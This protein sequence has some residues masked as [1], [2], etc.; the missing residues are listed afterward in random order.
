MSHNVIIPDGPIPSPSETNSFHTADS[1]ESIPDDNISYDSSREDD[2]M[3]PKIDELKHQTFGYSRSDHHNVLPSQRGNMHGLPP[4]YESQ[5]K[6]ALN[7]ESEVIHR[8]L[9]P[10]LPDDS[11]K[12]CTTTTGIITSCILISVSERISRL[13][14]NDNYRRRPSI[15]IPN[16]STPLITDNSYMS[17]SSNNDTK[18]AGCCNIL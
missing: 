5:P 4:G 2:D 16:E 15:D 8:S 11:S 6:L 18:S 13:N 9:K 12:I 1:I 3:T 10:P 14:S 17:N 7:D